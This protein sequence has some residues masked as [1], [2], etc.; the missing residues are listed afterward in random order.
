MMKLINERQTFRAQ[1]LSREYIDVPTKHQRERK[2]YKH[3]FMIL[4]YNIILYYTGVSWIKTNKQGIAKFRATP[5][6]MTDNYVRVIRPR[7]VRD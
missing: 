5:I 4:G 3:K 1:L 2:Q 7:D 6:K